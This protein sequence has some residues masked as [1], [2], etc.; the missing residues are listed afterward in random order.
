MLKFV[1]HPFDVLF[2]RDS[3]PFNIGGTASS[4]F[5]P[6]PHTFAGAISSIIYQHKQVSRPEVLKDVYGPFLYNEKENKTYFPKP[7]DIYGERKKKEINKLYSL[8]LSD[9]SRLSLF[10]FNNTNKPVDVERF[11]IYIGSEEVEGFYGFVG[12]EGL[13]KWINGERVKLNDIKSFDKIFDYED[14]VGI[15]QSMGTHTV[16]EE[17]G[18]YRIRFLGLKQDW[19]FVFYTEFDMEALPEDLYDEDKIKK[20]YES[21]LPQVLKL[22]G[23]MKN[24]HYRVEIEDIR[25]KFKKPD[26]NGDHFKI[27]FLTPATFNADL[28]PE[29]SGVKIISASIN[30]FENIGINSERLNIRNFVKRGIRAGSVFYIK[31]TGNINFG[32]FWFKSLWKEK[33]TVFIGGNL[34]IY[35]KY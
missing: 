18:L 23:E 1:I 20:F 7:A 13:Q 33:K 5:P 26:I 2:F 8:V 12:E 22:G 32:D 28:F 19:S 17:D 31:K 27:L 3:K 14:R 21:K 24:A 16:L 6:F 9:D 25:H 29:G 11:P 35:G 4:I 10:K 30:G 15:K 34:V